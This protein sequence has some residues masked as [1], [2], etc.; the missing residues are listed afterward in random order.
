MDRI[1]IRKVWISDFECVWKFKKVLGEDI[2]GGF[3]RGPEGFEIR[4]ADVTWPIAH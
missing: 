3:L 1:S 2:R 4:C